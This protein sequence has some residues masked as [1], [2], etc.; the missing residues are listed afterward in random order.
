MRRIVRASPDNPSFIAKCR[1]ELD[2]AWRRIRRLARKGPPP[3]FLHHYEL[4][5]AVGRAMH[6]RT[7]TYRYVLPTQLTAKLADPSVDSRSVQVARGGKGAFDARSV[8]QEVVVPFDQANH[9]VLRG[10]PEPYVNNPLR[11]PEIS[12]RFTAQQKDKQGWRDLCHILDAVEARQNPR[13]TRQVLVQVMAETFELLQQVAVIYPVP[14]R[15][16]LD[17]CL[18]LME[19]FLVERSGGDRPLALA[20]ALFGS[21]GKRFRLFAEVRR[22]SINAPDTAS[23]QVADLECLDRTGQVVVAVEIKDQELTI[24]HIS[25]KLPKARE[26]GVSEFFFLVRNGIAAA[27]RSRA[28]ALLDK[29]FIAGQN[30]Y[31]FD[32]LSFSRSALALVSEPGRHEFLRAVGSELDGYGSA[33]SDKQAWAALLSSS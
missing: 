30:L 8:C 24:K 5:E 29:E 25:D 16:S 26:R 31:V 13:F 9:S 15:I 12:E 6:S 17:R 20:S 4:R 11:V 28:E 33:L 21:L 22:R 10:S 14:K 23:G 7:K 18:L 1:R 2:A 3:A 27:D 19:R 32:L